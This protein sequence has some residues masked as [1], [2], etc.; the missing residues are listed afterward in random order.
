MGRYMLAVS[1]IRNIL[2]KKL[3]EEDFVIDKSGVKLV[4]IIGASFI[5]DETVIFGSLDTDY[6]AR[7]LE[8]YRSESL[9]VKDIPGRTP[10]IWEDVASHNG[11]INSNYGWCIWSVANRLQYKNVRR[12]LTNNPDSRRTSMIYTRPSM[13][14][15]SYHD[16][17]SDFVCTYG[18][19][20]FIR[21][22][23]LDAVVHMRS[24]DVVFGYKND[25][26]WQRYVLEM[27]ATDLGV[28]PGS[29]HWNVSSLHLY[30]RH[31]ELV[32]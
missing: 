17:M 21:E 25:R 7:E 19:D 27:L 13:H 10:K 18:V 16:G 15:D 31:F 6:A 8:W 29:I 23:R 24:N 22:G 14:E 26:Y 32:S 5:A 2:K 12:E 20:Y 30:E 3:L 28:V 11:K 1:N 4:E 9:F